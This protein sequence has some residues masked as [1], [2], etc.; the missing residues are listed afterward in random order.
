MSKAMRGRSRAL[1]RTMA[2]AVTWP[3]LALNAAALLL[4]LQAGAGAPH[5]TAGTW[6]RL[7]VA[8]G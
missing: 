8:L 5:R 6:L 3:W 7:V 2:E 4:L 1:C